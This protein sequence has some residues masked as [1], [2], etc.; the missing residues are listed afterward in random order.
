VTEDGKWFVGLALDE[1]CQPDQ[2][3]AR[4]EQW[5]KQVSEQMLK[6]A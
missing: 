3:D 6:T 4:I 1:D 5:S 2:T